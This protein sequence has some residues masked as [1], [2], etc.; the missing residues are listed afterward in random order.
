MKLIL[1]EKHKFEF[2]VATLAAAYQNIASEQVDAASD[3]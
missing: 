2:I 1:A 3:L